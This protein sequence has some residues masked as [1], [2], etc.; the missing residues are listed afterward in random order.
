MMELRDGRG[1]VRWWHVPAFTVALGV[2]CAT[3]IWVG[4]DRAGALG[5]LAIMAV[6]A[7]VLVLGGRSELVRG[8]RG[9]GRDEYWARLDLRASLF[10]GYVAL[11]AIIAMCLW[12]WAHGRDGTPYAQLGAL[13]GVG[14]LAA[15]AVLRW[16]G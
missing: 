15:V 3:A 4:G 1:R 10:G 16:R 9:D 11:T 7:G 2:V 14:Y 6:L 5:A 8:L 13:A 12:E